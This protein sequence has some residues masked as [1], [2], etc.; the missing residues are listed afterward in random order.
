MV[1]T[2]II[3]VV[4]IAAIAGIVGTLVGWLASTWWGIGVG[5]GV[6]A[7]LGGFCWFVATNLNIQ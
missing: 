6:A 7:V 3:S 2:I 5:L 1:K 4:V